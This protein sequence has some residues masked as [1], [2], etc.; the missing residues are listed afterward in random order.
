MRTATKIILSEKDQKIMAKVPRRPAFS[1][2]VFVVT[3]IATK[4]IHGIYS[5]EPKTKLKQNSALSVEVHAV[6]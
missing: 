4:K 3:N 2:E 1:K 5:K 6:Q